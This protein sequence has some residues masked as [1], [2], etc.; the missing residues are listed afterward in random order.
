MMPPLAPMAIFVQLNNLEVRLKRSPPFD[1]FC[2][3]MW[4]KSL[5][6]QS[7]PQQ[8]LYP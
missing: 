6:S 3:V 8:A 5:V 7:G 4:K 2:R 1:F